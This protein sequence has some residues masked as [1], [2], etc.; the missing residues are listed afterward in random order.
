MFGIMIKL[1]RTCLI[2][3][4]AIF[5]L[6]ACGRNPKEW[7]TPNMTALTPRLQTVFEKTKT[8][9]FG[10]FLVD[11]PESTDVVWGKTIVP[12]DVSVY[13][14]GADKVK[15]LAQKLI[16]DLKNEKAINHDYVPLL[17]SVDDLTQ[18][19]GTLITGYEDFQA[20]NGLK[21]SGY[22]KLNNDGVVINARPLRA[23]KDRTV[24]LINGIARRLRHR[25]GH[26]VPAEPGNCIES[27]FLMDTPNPTEED[28]LE[29]ISIG[30]RLKEFSDA[31]FSIHVAPSNPDNPEGDSLETQFKRTFADMTSP[32]EKKV[33]A[34]TKIFRQSARQIH[35]WKTGF[36]VL[37]RTPDEDGSFSHHDFR[38]K[39]VGV[40]HDAFKPYADIQFQTG[41][42][43][44]AAGR[45]KASLTDEEA[46]AV[47]DKI[48]STIR[49]RPTRAAPARTADADSGPRR[50]LGELAATGRVCPQ[51]GTWE[52]VDT[53]Q[54]IEGGMRLHIRAGERMPHAISHG[55]SSL[56]QKLKGERSVYRA[57]T[58]WKLVDYD[59][60]PPSRDIA[61]KDSA[62]A[63]AGDGNRTSPKKEG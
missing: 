34:N 1:R 11:V 20:I 38:M 26:E 35:D 60:A 33:L 6:S 61:A 2:P 52:S 42:S 14:N 51:T 49:L 30:L 29:H 39:F 10:R 32:E 5:L 58:M 24:A 9:C 48:T 25:A 41:V 31:H 54:D 17:I 63:D 4:V 43:D 37:M 46:L 47:W 15:G 44:N 57:A 28:L 19:E 40:P 50:P 3:L 23:A 36:E 21:M 13:P 18:P 53:V 59:D 55:E 27:A 56:W 16:D 8:V 22:F 62:D 12:L 7:E 45:T